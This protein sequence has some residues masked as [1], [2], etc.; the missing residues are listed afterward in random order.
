MQDDKEKLE[1]QLEALKFFPNNNLVKQLRKQIKEKLENLTKLPAKM[2]IDVTTKR[3]EVNLARS[4]SQKKY[5]RYIRLIRN[6]FPQYSYAN[7]RSQ[8]SRRKKGKESFIPDVIWQ[9]PS[10]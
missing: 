3:Q 5:H 9:D 6:H 7:I 10:P 8:F 4:Q 1:K 2:L